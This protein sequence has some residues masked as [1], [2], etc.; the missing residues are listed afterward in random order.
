M[1]KIEI[2]LMGKRKMC[3]CQKTIIV[4]CWEMRLGRTQEAQMPSRKETAENKQIMPVPNFEFG[5][6]E[7]RLPSTSKSCLCQITHCGNYNLARG[8]Q[9]NLP[10]LKH[11]FR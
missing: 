8:E 4:I 2:R 1:S 10:L 9:Q 5:I 11:K 7:I 6:L 3:P